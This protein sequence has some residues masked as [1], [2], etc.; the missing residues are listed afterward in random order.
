MSLKEAAAVAL[1]PTGVV[2]SRN[3]NVFPDFIR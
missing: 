3:R 2:E 1:V